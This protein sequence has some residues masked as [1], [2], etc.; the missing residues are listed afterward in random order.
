MNVRE[1]GN[2]NSALRTVLSIFAAALLSVSCV[3]VTIP[4]NEFNLA[5]VAVEAAREADAP[6]FAPGHWHKAEEAYKQAQRLYK[7]RHYSKA[8]R[9]FVE[10]KV[11][12]ERA[13]NAARVIRFQT[14]ETSP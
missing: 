3:T 9:L 8:Q 14:G 12:A 2:I 5:R 6:R 1:C 10:A 4:V 7:D 11:H 13:E